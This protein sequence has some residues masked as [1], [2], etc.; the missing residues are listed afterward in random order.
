MLVKTAKPRQL[1]RLVVNLVNRSVD[2]QKLCG[3]MHKILQE[4][5]PERLEGSEASKLHL[6]DNSQGV[7][8]IS[9][10]NAY[11]VYPLVN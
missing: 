2:K 6:R 4:E 9:Q 1:P 5:E 7:T 8:W 11:L 3:P 10:T